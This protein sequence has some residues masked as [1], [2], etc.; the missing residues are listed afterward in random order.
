MHI[1]HFAATRTGVTE[2]T[3]STRGTRGG[4]DGERCIDVA[5]EI[6]AG[7]RCCCTNHT[8][9]DRGEGQHSG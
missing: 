9:T 6:V 2:S 7:G 8:A 5:R 4:C 3:H 1:E